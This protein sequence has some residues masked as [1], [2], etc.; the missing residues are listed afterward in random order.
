M[1]SLNTIPN[2]GSFGDV[3][4]KLNDNFSKVGQSLTTLENVAIANK[5]YFDTLAS[6]QAAFPS[7]KAGNIAYV[8]NVASS[9]GYYIYNVVSGVW[10]ATTTEA[11]A[12]GVAISDYAQH[13]YSSSPKTLKQVDDEV[14]QLAGDVIK[15]DYGLGLIRDASEGITEDEENGSML[16]TVGGIKLSDGKLDSSLTSLR[17]I[18]KQP[19]P[20]NWTEIRVSTI[21]SPTLAFALYRD[22][23]L[24]KTFPTTSTGEMTINSYL[25]ANQYSCYYPFNRLSDFYVRIKSKSEQLIGYENITKIEEWALAAKNENLSVTSYDA[26]ILTLK[27]NRTISNGTIIPYGYTDST[28]ILD[29]GDWN[30]IITTLPMTQDAG[31]FLLDENK[32]ILLYLK[33]SSTFSLAE[34]KRADYQ[35][36]KYL[37]TC[38]LSSY[39]NIF[40]LSIARNVPNMILANNY[41]Y[42]IDSVIGFG[43][44]TI[45]IPYSEEIF[46]ENGFIKASNGLID[47][48]IAG[49]KTMKSISLPSSWRE[50]D[51]SMFASSA[52]G[53]VFF[54]EV[55]KHIGSYIN[56][57]SQFSDQIIKRDYFP[58]AKFVRASWNP[59]FGAFKMQIRYLEAFEN[60]FANRE[61][62]LLSQTR[63][64][65][66][67]L[68]TFDSFNLNNE[69]KLIK[70]TIFSSA[71]DPVKYVCRVPAIVTA[72]D[73][74]II[75]ACEMRNNAIDDTG[76]YD[77]MIKR[78]INDTW[79]S[80]LLFPYNTTYGRAMNPSFT[81]DRAGANGVAG[82]IYLF[83]NTVLDDNKIALQSSTNELDILYRFSDDNGVNWSPIQS[84]KNLWNANE[85]IAY[86][87]SPANGIQL[88]DG[89]LV[90][91]AMCAKSDYWRSGILYKKPN[92]GW[93]FSRHT[94]RYGDNECVAVE[95]KNT[96]I[97][98]CRYNGGHTFRRSVYEYNLAK[99]EFIFH[100][101]D[102]TFETYMGVQA[103]IIKTTL[104]NRVVYLMSFPDNSDF[105]I[106]DTQYSRRNTTLWASLDMV[107]W[108]RVLNFSPEQNYG[109]SVL[110]EHNGR[111]CVLYEGAKPNIEFIDLTN[112]MPLIENS[113][114]VQLG[115]TLEDRLQDLFKTA[116]F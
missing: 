82:R 21:E 16:T 19:L 115:R 89:T 25:H 50:I 4:A 95:G 12:V 108:I 36:A 20:E 75:A 103:S 44:K 42:D 32:S 92:Q 77:V 90:I 116:T 49:Y 28:K 27:G 87:V 1:D 114:F 73:G 23:I 13:G 57:L 64:A 53:V 24:V 38:F 47:T 35:S 104:K 69:A 101:S 54:D 2:S 30:R 41:K 86:L 100:E 15:K 102:R 96:I 46:N 29:L 63:I 61:D 37:A 22:G 105:Y 7:P 6:L 68:E 98:N 94:P 70:E 18:E 45:T 88:A 67:N 80:Q 10:T 58:S 66:P 26:S 107:R 60:T 31:L 79:Q 76:Q 39:I 83:V 56:P 111:L 110:S 97:L 113:V 85:Y 55:G 17:A 78:K 5:G 33:G 99:D 48:S 40:K 72:N 65:N 106:Y 71:D 11:P 62:F 59:S 91:P 51:I 74:T 93:V 109:Y 3:S 52:S 112:S 9:T 84:L 81:I 43:F 8:A 34:I 14:V